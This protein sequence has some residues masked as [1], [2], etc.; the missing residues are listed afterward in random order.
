[1]QNIR[2]AQLVSEA[3]LAFTKAILTRDQTLDVYLHAAAGPVQIGGGVY[4]SQTINALPF[5]PDEQRFFA[6]VAADVDR[7]LGLTIRLVSDPEASDVAIY[8]DSDFAVSLANTIGVAIPNQTRRKNW[9]EL[10]LNNQ[11]FDGQI[12]LLRYALIHEFA[13]ALGL[14]HP[15]DGSDGDLVNGISDPWRSVFPGD[16]V[17]AYRN[18]QAGG[19]P[20]AYTANDWLALET[21]W[22]VETAA[23]TLAPEPPQLE[24]APVAAG[25]AATSTAVTNLARPTL[26]GRAEAGATVQLFGSDVL[27][28]LPLGAATV[29]GGGWWTLTLP[30]PLNDGLYSLRAIARDRAG[31]SSDPSRPLQLTVDT[32]APR[33]EPLGPGKPV[34]GAAGNLWSL[35]LQASEA[36]TWRLDAGS[37]QSRFSLDVDGLLRLQDG[38]FSIDDPRR[39]E[40]SVTAVDRAGNSSNLQ[41]VVTVEPTGLD[42]PYRPTGSALVFSQQPASLQAVRSLGS[43]D[44]ISVDAPV[45]AAVQLVAAQDWQRGYVACN[46]GSPASRGTGQTIPLEGL[47][48]YSAVVQGDPR[49]TVT[50]ALDATRDSA[51]FLDDA[52]SSFHGSLQAGLQANADGLRSQA[53]LSNIERIIMGGGGGLSIVDLTSSNYHCSAITVLGGGVGAGRSVFW[54]SDGNDN[55]EARGADAIVFGGAGA[56]TYSLSTGRETLQYVFGGQARD[57]IIAGALDQQGGA[58]RFDPA[59]DTIEL[60]TDAGA[61]AQEVSPSLSS[62]GDGTLLS[63]GGNQLLFEGQTFGLEMLTLVPRTIDAAGPFPLA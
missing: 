13:H 11:I 53:R 24:L 7:R 45:P 32:T 43:A 12:F 30:D 21:I 54:G 23:D 56:N 9:W 50:L 18:P 49:A 35:Q 34:A 6:D 27:T 33:L 40:I 38:H 36:V 22:G 39:I 25:Q 31:N 16:T 15:F 48:R 62:Q 37:Q 17:M 42:L 4:G 14:E 10:I 58:H 29:D 46:V 2:P 44:L 41:R 61:P 47:G 51:L 3:S 5:A 20:Q 63:W 28:G 19:W 57:R 26:Q 8:L 59:L 60:W 1:M 52:Y 55:F